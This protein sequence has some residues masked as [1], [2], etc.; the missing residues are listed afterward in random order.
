MLTHRAPSSDITF[1]LDTSRYRLSDNLL[2]S[3]DLHH[4]STGNGQMNPSPT[5]MLRVQGCYCDSARSGVVWKLV[6]EAA[7]RGVD[8]ALGDGGCMLWA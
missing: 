3:V 6:D 4:G 8:K 2:S 5:A 1:E 7:G